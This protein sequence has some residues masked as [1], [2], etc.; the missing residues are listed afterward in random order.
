MSA[1]KSFD[2]DIILIMGGRNKNIDFTSLNNIIESRVKKLILIGEAADA[3][4][5]MIHFE[6]KIIIKDFTDAFYYASAISISGDTVLLS[7]GCASF[8]M[9]KNYEERGKY[10]KSLVYKLIEISKE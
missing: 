10:F 7:P 4:N 8:D 9:F 1:L 5:E 6:N 2:K 3:L